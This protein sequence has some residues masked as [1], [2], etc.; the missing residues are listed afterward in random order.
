MLKAAFRC[1][2]FVTS[3]LAVSVAANA[4][5]FVTTERSIAPGVR[6]SLLPGVLAV[7]AGSA[8]P[9]GANTFGPCILRIVHGTAESMRSSPLAVSAKPARLS[10]ANSP[11]PR[12]L[13]ALAAWLSDRF[14]LPAVH[15][16]PR[17][18][19]VPAETIVRV[20]LG[21]MVQAP[22]QVAAKPAMRRPEP[23]SES[24][25]IVAVYDDRTRTIYLPS[26]WTGETPVEQ[27]VLIHEMVH[28][29]QNLA[30]EK[31]A[32]AQARDETAYAAQEAWLALFGENFFAAFDT[33]PMSLL[34]RTRCGF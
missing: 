6:D 7:S 23:H 20:R 17:I 19:F 24:S 18:A 15:N 12:L 27:S 28:H 26:T 22:M 32:C 3:L 29:I 14:D 4:C 8:G 21:A 34:L 13:D 25:T 2:L 5:S 33:D 16:P 1:L 11:D 9:A 30:G 10:A 31:F